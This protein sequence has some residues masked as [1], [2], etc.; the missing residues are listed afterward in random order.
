MSVVDPYA[1][2]PCGSGQKFKWCCQKVEA[3]AERADRLFHG[4]QLDASLE[5][6]DEGLRKVP[7]NPWLLIRKALIFERLERF[8]QARPVLERVLADHPG[9]VG[10][11]AILVRVVLQGEGPGAGAYELQ[12]ALT[13]LPAESRGV[14]ASLAQI[15][16]VLLGR[17]G[18]VPAA[19]AHLELAEDL[20]FDD[21]ATADSLRRA[22]EGDP[23]VSPWLKNP[24]R[25]A[26]APEGL[27]A[28]AKAQFDEAVEWAEG[29]LWAAA[30]SRFELLSAESRGPEADRNLGLCRLWLADD[31]GA[32]EALRR[33]IGRSEATPEAVDLEALCQRI[34]PPDPDDLI[35]HFHLTWPLRKR[36][37]L[38]ETLNGRSDVQEQGHGPLEPEN[39]DSPEVDVFALLDR[40]MPAKETHLERPADVP[41]V[42]G[43]VLVGQD[44]AILDAYEDGKLHALTDHFRD[45]AGH[46]LP[47]AHPKTKVVQKISRSTIALATDWT[48]PEAT[49]RAD[50]D[51]ISRLESRRIATEV[52]PRTPMPYLDG[53]TPDQ[54]A[55][56]GGFEVPLRAAI[57]Q[58][59]A[60]GGS[61][62]GESD[63]SALRERMGVSPEPP[64]DVE[65]VDVE[66]VHLGRLF[67]VPAEGLEDDR[68]TSLYLRS[69]E[70]MIP[71]ALERAARA[72]VER[73][74]SESRSHVDR[75]SVY[76]DLSNLAMTRDDKDE[77]FGWIE[78][79]RA[80]EPAALKSRN[81][82]RWEMLSLRLRARTEAPESWVPTLAM[83]LDRYSQDR[84]S[85][86]ALMGNLLDMGLVQLVPN[87]D[88]PDD[89][90]LDSRRLQ[91]V[92]TRYG[93]RVTT[94][95]GALGVSA[96]N[97]EIWT[98]GG[99]PAGGGGGGG[100][101]TPGSSQPASASG[102]EKPKL[103]LPGR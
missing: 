33:S 17:A 69:R 81:A 79:G 15:L 8:A 96:A 9:H 63:F 18:Y 50:V 4:N 98:P 92:L 101:W 11:H 38:L 44:V 29:G 95:S 48:F 75:F 20:G 89:V 84:E 6:L 7:G 80:A 24:Y 27:P 14:L 73:P 102:G 51:R 58:F 10:A 36:E 72:L 59:E 5:A 70:A 60:S 82:I 25:I 97:P 99:S 103:I 45:L 86:Q 42:L 74:L 13:T 35:E 16:A 76:A 46:A 55:K 85:S 49:T 83:I 47:P 54:A 23:A 88:N 30:A 87:P 34:A 1:P 21:E 19:L 41:R 67:R 61:W 53:Q 12:R 100:L 77:A 64:I 91:A 56:R 32:F 39:E 37:A 40:P 68:L 57:C 71:Q 65:T 43:R 3:F 31:S 52:W 78:R 2:C 22:L 90:L 94:A 93:P 62:T 26:Q 28:A 66:D